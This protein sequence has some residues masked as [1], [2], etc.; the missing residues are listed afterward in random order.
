MSSTVS[1][2]ATAAGRWSTARFHARR[3]SSQLV[4]SGVTY[5]PDRRSRSASAVVETAF[6]A[7]TFMD[8][9][10]W[11]PHLSVVGLPDELG[12]SLRTTPGAYELRLRAELLR[13]VLRAP[14]VALRAAPVARFAGDL[15]ALVLRAVVLRA[16]DLRAV[17]L[18]ALV[19]R[20]PVLFLV[21]E[22]LRDRVAAPFFAALRRLVA[23][24][25]RVRA[26]F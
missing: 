9:K 15:R 25:L 16:V 21:L 18:R 22:L 24:R 23:A 17:D 26:P 8:A 3:A 13:A 20:A 12:S 14:P 10:V 5:S 11:P 4:S 2:I 7:I 19:L 1:G 6:F